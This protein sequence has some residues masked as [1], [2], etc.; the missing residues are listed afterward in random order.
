MAAMHSYKCATCGREVEYEGPLP[1]VYP[2]CSSRCKMAD[3][4][5]W[6]RE[7]YTIDRDL[8][9]EELPSPPPPEE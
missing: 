3:L 1:S 6:L 7:Q 5:K 9:P 8:G 4:G 2:F